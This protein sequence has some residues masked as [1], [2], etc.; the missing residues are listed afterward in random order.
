MTAKLYASA[1]GSLMGERSANDVSLQPTRQLSAGP[2]YAAERH[3]PDRFRHRDLSMVQPPS[4][5][6]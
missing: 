3:Q 2:I 6:F 1:D 4:E 5:Y